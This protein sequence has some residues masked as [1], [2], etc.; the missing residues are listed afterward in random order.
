LTRWD[1]WTSH[2]TALEL[3]TSIDTVDSVDVLQEPYAR[4]ARTVL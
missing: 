1:L 2:D 3:C 4:P